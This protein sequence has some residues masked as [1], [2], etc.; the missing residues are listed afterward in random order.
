MTNQIVWPEERYSSFYKRQ[1][2]LCILDDFSAFSGGVHKYTDHVVREILKGMRR[3]MVKDF[4]MSWVES[5]NLD[6]PFNGRN[7]RNLLGGKDSQHAIWAVFDIYMK[8]TQPILARGFSLEG[9]LERLGLVVADFIDPNQCTK[10]PADLDGVFEA[11]E[12]NGVQLFLS[13]QCLS[14]RRFKLAHLIH[15]RTG[16]PRF[17]RNA[18]NGE[19]LRDSGVRIDRGVL[20]PQSNGWLLMVRKLETADIGLGFVSSNGSTLSI[21]LVSENDILVLSMR[22]SDCDR[23]SH[24][25]RAARLIS[26]EEPA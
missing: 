7:I 16:Q 5:P 2:R 19:L 23:R 11:T 14:E 4:E 15:E 25:S 1:L 24:L 10:T 18:A 21:R 26:A 6:Q 8:L 3:G 22:K 13:V 17:E 9:H 12:N 20:V